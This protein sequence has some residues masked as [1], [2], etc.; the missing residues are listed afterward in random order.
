MNNHGGLPPLQP[1]RNGAA[2]S[3]SSR[4]SSRGSR[5]GGRTP[6]PAA[7]RGKRADGRRQ[8]S[9]GR[10][11]RKGG[12]HWAPFEQCWSSRYSRA[13]GRVQ[14]QR[15]PSWRR[16]AGLAPK[17]LAAARS[18]GDLQSQRRQIVEW[19]FR[20]GG[21][22]SRDARTCSRLEGDRAEKPALRTANRLEGPRCGR[23]AIDG[24]AR[25]PRSRRVPP[26]ARNLALLQQRAGSSPDMG[27]RL[28]RRS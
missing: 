18:R 17:A 5:H 15:S 2:D 14:R 9:A 23:G 16:V 22:I 3:Q 10:A 27:Q 7:P 12:A 19:R 20:A 21:G 25:R 26:P 8:C 1:S 24:A 13:H 11:V 4:A 28:V 6:S